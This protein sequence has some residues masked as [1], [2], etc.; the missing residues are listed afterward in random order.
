MKL[1][2]YPIRM[3][4]IYCFSKLFKKDLIFFTIVSIY[5]KMQVENRDIMN[6]KYSIFYLP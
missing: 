6:Y 5:L 1:T 3:S 2:I 4:N